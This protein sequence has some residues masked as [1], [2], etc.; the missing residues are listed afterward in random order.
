MIGIIHLSDIHIENNKDRVINRGEKIFDGT[1]NQL[2]TVNQIIIVISGDIANS[3]YKEQYEVAFEMLAELKCRLENYTQKKITVIMVPGNHDCDFSDS[4]KTEIRSIIIK[5]IIQNRDIKD[6]MIN[7]CCNIQNNYKEFNNIFIEENNK[8][9]QDNLLE[10]TEYNDESQKIYFVG[11]NMSWISERKET[12]NLFFPLERYS[13]KLKSLDG[14]VISVL[15]QPSK[16]CHPIDSNQ[17]DDGLNKYSNI[18]FQGHEHNSKVYTHQEKNLNTIYIKGGALQP[19][20]ESNESAFNLVLLDAK[21]LTLNLIE[22]SFKEKLYSE[23]ES[24]ELNIVLRDIKKEFEIT[25]NQK[26]FIKDI[27]ANIIKGDNHTLILSDVFV[28]PDLTYLSRKEIINSQ[29]DREIIKNSKQLLDKGGNRYVF[30]TGEEK[31]GKTSL[32]KMLF[33]D[34]YTQG[35]VPIL[36]NGD[37]YNYDGKDDVRKDIN[38]L[39]LKQYGENHLEE[40][41]QLDKERIIIII[42][43][44]SNISQSHKIREK[45]IENIMYYYGSIFILTSDN[46]NIKESLSSGIESLFGNNFQHYKIKE[47]GYSMKNKIIHKWNSIDIDE[48]ITEKQLLEK[49][50]ADIKMVNIV[51]RKNYIPS[52]PFYILVLLQ[53]IKAGTPNNFTNSSYGYYY[54]YLIMQSLSKITSQQGEISSVRTFIVTLAYEMFSIGNKKLSNLELRKLHLDYCEKYDISDSFSKFINFENII[55]KMVKYNILKVTKDNKYKFAYEYIYYYCVGIYL[56]ENISEEETKKIISKMVN[57]LYVEEYANILMFIIHHTKDRYILNEIINKT[58]SIFSDLAYVNLDDDLGFVKEVQMKLAPLTVEQINI[59]K[60]REKR[61][62]RMDSENEIAISKTEKNEVQPKDISIEEEIQLSAID[63]L[64]LSFKSMEILGQVLKN[65]WGKLEKELKIE[66]G[67]ELYKVGLRGLSETYGILRNSS[68]ELLERIVSEIEEDNIVNKADVI[69]KIN[70]MVYGFVVLFTNSFIIKI[71]SCVGD[72]KLSKTYDNIYE[73]MKCSSVELINLCI[74]LDCYSGKF[75]KEEVEIFISK[76][77]VNDIKYLI[78]RSFVQKYLYM[79]CDDRTERQI[80][81]DL[82]KLD[83]ISQKRVLLKNVSK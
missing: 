31:S 17:F 1:K 59:F 4:G 44:F 22:Y 79:Y 39:F 81:A 60:S 75:P 3:G 61:F 62:E 56:A 14:I 53:S 7:E 30:I 23:I 74:K 2:L 71:V 69:N 48:S 70:T 11:I 37:N 16:W 54:E 64:N 63:N 42:D 83:H 46:I 8:L 34:F 6:S 43:D 77:K 27:G 51:F 15:H 78:L 21:K 10:I 65:Y 67:Q 50:D 82:F 28:Y 38:K 80:I 72:N 5:Q 76:C 25:E 52:V 20:G 55:D 66:I 32:A 9:Y 12:P 36:I 33:K 47:F 35:K 19:H 29:V 13:E 49:D 26:E 45:L 18:V 41:K 24:Q 68:D 73:N 57:K 58:K 40:F